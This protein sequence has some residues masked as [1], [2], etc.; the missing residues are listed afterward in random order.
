MRRTH[1][2]GAL[3]HAGLPSKPSPGSLEQF[4]IRRSQFGGTEHRQGTEKAV[5]RVSVPLINSLSLSFGLLVPTKR[6]SAPVPYRVWQWTNVSRSDELWSLLPACPFE[7]PFSSFFFPFPWGL[8]ISR[9]KKKGKKTRRPSAAFQMSLVGTIDIREL[10][11]GFCLFVLVLFLVCSLTS[12]TK[13]QEA[14]NAL[15]VSETG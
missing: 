4:A 8:P 10:L 15:A 12:D 9:Q 5:A 7:A 14:Q 6:L 3:W 2:G 1:M 11:T 13:R